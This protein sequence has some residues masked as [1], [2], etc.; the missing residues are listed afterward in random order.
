[1]VHHHVYE[2][3]LKMTCTTMKS[4]V[5][6]SENSEGETDLYVPSVAERLLGGSA[7]HLCVCV[8]RCSNQQ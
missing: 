4:M 6:I 2:S 5:E 8:F 1:M 7:K 3:V